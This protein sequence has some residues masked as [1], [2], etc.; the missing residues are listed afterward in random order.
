MKVYLG[1]DHRG[2]ELKEFLKEHLSEVEIVDKGAY[3]INPV[4][5]YVDFAKAVAEEVVQAPDNRGILI[6]GSGV[7]VDI[8]ANKIDGVRAGLIE[9]ATQAKSARMDDDI[10]IL[11]LSA[12]QLTAEKAL[13]ITKVFLSTPF[14]QEERHQRR[15]DKIKELE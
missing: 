15:L 8:A 10:N 5:D 4:D 7:G 1:A 2:F 9:E 3:E 11:C 6:C 12:D 14:S 13:E